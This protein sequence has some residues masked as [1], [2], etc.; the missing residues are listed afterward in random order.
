MLYHRSS[1]E[2]EVI[3]RTTPALLN[4]G[5]H[6]ADMMLLGDEFRKELFDAYLALRGTGGT[7]LR[8]RDLRPDWAFVQSIIAAGSL[9]GGLRKHEETDASTALSLST[10]TAG[11]TA[12]SAMSNMRP[13]QALT[14][15][16][17]WQGTPWNAPGSAAPSARTESWSGYLGQGVPS[18]AGAWP[19]SLNSNIVPVGTRAREDVPWGPSPWNT[20]GQSS[21]NMGRTAASGSILSMQQ[22]IASLQPAGGAGGEIDPEDI[23]IQTA[24][25]MFQSLGIDP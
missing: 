1:A 13:Q 7:A 6:V 5:L 9:Y 18:V 22:S 3:S 20:T 10:S 24:V 14:V 12:R 2:A 25:S 23:G 15:P 11:V 4:A 8:L 21:L 17:G 19:L 16:S